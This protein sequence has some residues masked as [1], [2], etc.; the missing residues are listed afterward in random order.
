M[1]STSFA[2]V[3]SSPTI[4]KGQSGASSG[5]SIGFRGR[6]SVPS[7]G[8]G[9]SIAT[10]NAGDV[11]PFKDLT[12]GR[13]EGELQFRLIHFWE[14]WN[15]LTK[16][17]IG[18]EMLLIDEEGTVV[19]GF[20]PYGRIETYR[21][22]MKAGGTYRLNK[23]F[24]SANKT[25]YSVAEASVT[26][27]F[28]WNSVLSDL[29]DS[30]IHFPDDR[31]RI[32]GYKE[33]DAACDMKGALYDYV[34]HI[35]LV[36]GQV[37]NDGLLLGEAGI[38]APRRVDLHVQTHDDPVLKLCLWDKAASEFCEKF[39]ASGG[40][41]RVI[42]V[43]TLNPKRF[44][45]LS[46][47]SMTPTRVFLDGD[48]Q[49]TRDYLSWLNSN[50]EV[51]NKVKPDVV[52]KPEPASL[53]ELFAYMKQS[54]AKVAWFECTATIDD[55]VHDS[56]WYYI[57]C[58]ECHT[59]ATKGATTLMCK[60][61]GKDKIV[62]VPQYLARLS[63]YDNKDQAVFVVLGDAGE[64]LFGKKAS[65]LV[66]SYY[67]ANESVGADH[68]VPVPQAMVDT[69]GQTRKFIVKV[70]T[71]NLDGKTQT[72]TVTKVLP[73]E[74]P[75]PETKSGESVD[76]E[77]VNGGEDHAAESVKRVADGVESAVVKRNKCG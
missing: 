41:A 38:A 37:P 27:T 68:I 55:V 43:T 62:G 11:I 73:L 7:G 66:E 49:E 56:R 71:H 29:E 13:H 59:K 61:C 21:R 58:G 54:S 28:S 47:S 19:Q 33:F 45:V 76:G 25:N 64:E 17:L 10:G 12:L 4:P 46:L 18:I 14:A 51:A 36:N 67:Q 57:G 2:A 30:T 9:K 75:G 77:P 40:A 34:G 63:V 53:G 70:S 20:I 22:H 72:L 52:V 39:R 31:F 48:V 23:F 16:V 15:S 50:L 5:L 74:A 35:K 65:D 24:G 26:I 44:G 1:K 3:S 60:K 6:S 32:Q 69:I 8:K 42:L